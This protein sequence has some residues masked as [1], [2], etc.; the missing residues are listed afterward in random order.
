MNNPTRIYCSSCGAI[1]DF[2]IN[3]EYIFCKYCGSK[4]RLEHEAMRTNINVGNINITAKTDLDNL[5]SYTKYLIGTQQYGKA[6]EVLSAIML[7]GCDDYRV[8]ICKTMIDLNTGNDRSLFYAMEKLKSLVY[9]QHDNEITHAIEELMAYKG[10]EGIT[11]L[12][13][14][15]FNE[16]YDIVK[17]CVEHGSDV[18][19]I[20]WAA[21]VTPISIMFMPLPEDFQKIDGTTFRD[22]NTV[23]I[24]RNYLMNHGATDKWR[25]S[26]D[27]F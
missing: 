21:E 27:L 7:S 16:K 19:A 15:T 22:K 23:K 11:V 13:V 17:F 1:L 2:E 24:I 12:H 3:R 14:A 25:I 10:Y 18:N 9:T 6:D 8:Y 5:V 26:H 20:C 4:N